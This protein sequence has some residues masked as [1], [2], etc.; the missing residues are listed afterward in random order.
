MTW[1]IRKRR[2][3][4]PIM[5]ASAAPSCGSVVCISA[6]GVTTRKPRT[7]PYHSI[8]RSRS[9]TLTPTWLI[10]RGLGASVTRSSC[11]RGQERLDRL[12]E[13][14]PRVGGEVVARHRDR[15]RA[16]DTRRDLVGSRGGDV[17]GAGDGEH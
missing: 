10:G 16:R 5:S 6:G 1:A 7:A 3:R 12:V 11:H 14:W 9:S 8:A 2:V 13:L 15:G 17:L 4:D